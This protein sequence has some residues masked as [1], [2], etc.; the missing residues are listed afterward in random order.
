MLILILLNLFDMTSCQETITVLRSKLKIYEDG[1]FISG[2]KL[3]DN[4]MVS[5]EDI[6]FCIRFNY[7]LLG[8]Y[9]GRSRL[10]SIADWKDQ[11]G[12]NLNIIKCKY[13]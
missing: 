13:L 2:A 8:Q 3:I 6:S 11:N 9:E 4:R 7:K 10:I 1:Q 5:V 12:V